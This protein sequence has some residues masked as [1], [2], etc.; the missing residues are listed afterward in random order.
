MPIA[1][2]KT[3]ADRLT[4][5]LIAQTSAGKFLGLMQSLTQAVRW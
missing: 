1:E 4:R 2:C 5:F 3:I